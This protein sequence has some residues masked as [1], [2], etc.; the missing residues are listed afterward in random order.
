MGSCL[1]E[2][3]DSTG[4]PA[5]LPYTHDTWTAVKVNFRIVQEHLHHYPTHMT[6]GQLS[7]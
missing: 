6:H 2:L 4:A 5:P 3:Q 7:K 1:S